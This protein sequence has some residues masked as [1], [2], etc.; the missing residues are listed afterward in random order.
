LY[1]KEHHCSLD[2][3]DYLEHYASAELLQ[4]Q[5]TEQDFVSAQKELNPSVP[6]TE[7]QR[8]EQLQSSFR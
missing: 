2:V 3:R 5:V 6:L 4:V 8:Y 7:L 1:E